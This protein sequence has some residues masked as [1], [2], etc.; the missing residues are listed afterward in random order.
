MAQ[1]YHIEDDMNQSNRSAPGLC[2]AAV[3]LML[4]ACTTVPGETTTGFTAQRDVRDRVLALARSSDPQC[5]Q[6]KIMGT[7]ITEV[8]SDGRAAAETWTVEQ[9]GRRVPYLV[10]FPVKKGGPVTVRAER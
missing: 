6:P 8:H 3:T 9:C 2:A 7:E 4:A 1:T 10:S 5:K